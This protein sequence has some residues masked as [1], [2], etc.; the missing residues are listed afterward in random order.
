VQQL[1]AQ[2]QEEEPQKKQQEQAELWQQVPQQVQI[3][4]AAEKISGALAPGR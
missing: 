3:N 1:Q 2:V 4:R